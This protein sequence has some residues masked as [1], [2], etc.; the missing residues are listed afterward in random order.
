MQ[1]IDSAKN[2]KR[3]LM[4]ATMVFKKGQRKDTV[5]DIVEKNPY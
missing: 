4:M 3:I 2:G 1:Q 5:L